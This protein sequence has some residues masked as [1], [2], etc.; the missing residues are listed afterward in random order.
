VSEVFKTTINRILTKPADFVT[1]NSPEQLRHD[2]IVA[3]VKAFL[4]AQGVADVEFGNTETAFGTVIATKNFMSMIE[5]LLDIK[6][7][8][9]PQ[10]AKSR[11]P[12]LVMGSVSE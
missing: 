2:R 8:P 10:P 5:Q 6:D 1:D 9:A 12:V 4:Q 3:D 7:G 11:E